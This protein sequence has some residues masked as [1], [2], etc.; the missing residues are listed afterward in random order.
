VW[1]QRGQKV[2]GCHRRATL[3]LVGRLWVTLGECSIN[4]V[5]GHPRSPTITQ[6]HPIILFWAR[7]NHIIVPLI[8]CFGS[9]LITA[10]MITL[11]SNPLL[12]SLEVSVFYNCWPGGL[13]SVVF[14][15]MISHNKVATM[16][17]VEKGQNCC[18]S[19]CHYGLEFSKGHMYWSRW[20]T[21]KGSMTTKSSAT[22]TPR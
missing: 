22:Q 19:V 1:L 3:L 12:H 16:S 11:G 13:A 2:S 21:S 7:N 17:V 4:R 20:K 15:L 8:G 10:T 9:W 5:S 18:M 6:S 14:Q